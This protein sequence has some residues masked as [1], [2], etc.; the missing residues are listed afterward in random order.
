VNNYH[1]YDQPQIE[2]ALLRVLKSAGVMTGIANVSD[3]TIV[4]VHERL[5]SEQLDRLRDGAKSTDPDTNL[6]LFHSFMDSLPVDANGTIR[7]RAKANIGL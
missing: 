4:S 5:L 3:A 6:K 7:Y 1:G 2:G